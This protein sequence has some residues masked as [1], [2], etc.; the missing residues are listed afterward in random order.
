MISNELDWNDLRFFLTVARTRS[1]TKTATA[2]KVS[3]STV[4]RRIEAIE[5]SLRANLFAHHQTGYFLTDAGQDILKYAEEVEERILLL[6]SRVSGLDLRPVGTV[7]LATAETLASQLIIPALSRFSARFPDIT[8]EI[9]TGVNTVSIT[10]HD[11]DLALRLVRPEQNSLKIRRV[12]RMA[13][14]VYGSETYLRQHPAPDTLPL[15]RRG[16]ITWDSS[17]NHLPS[18]KWLSGTYPN[19]PATLVITSVVSQIAAVKASLGLAVLPCFIA[20]Q[21][22]E[23]V[24]VIP[25]EQVFAEDLWLVSHADLTASTRIRAVADFLVKIIAEAQLV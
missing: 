17:Y 24:E 5:N 7:R 18:A 21:N 10:R 16:F 14:A 13:S 25:T 4:A 1:L 8:L 22:S 11:A 20:S 9:I 19:A 23:M 15:D 12:G 2:L 6:A 3:Q